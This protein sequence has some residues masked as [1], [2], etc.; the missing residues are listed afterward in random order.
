VEKQ[1]YRRVLFCSSVI[2]RISVRNVISNHSLSNPSRRASDCDGFKN[3]A[4][5]GLCGIVTCFPWDFN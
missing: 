2:G 5:L 4:E 3:F 1:V